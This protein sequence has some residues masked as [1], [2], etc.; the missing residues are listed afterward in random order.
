MNLLDNQIF[1]VLLPNDL[2]KF[3][4]Y[5]AAEANLRRVRCLHFEISRCC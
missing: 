2:A 3:S 1:T 5:E 4:V